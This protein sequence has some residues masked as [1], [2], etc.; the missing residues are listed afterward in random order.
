MKKNL[1]ILLAISA[2]IAMFVISGC[3]KAV[4]PT[5]TPTPTPT[6]APTVKPDVDCPKVVSTE[7]FHYYDAI[8]ENWCPWDCPSCG[9]PPCESCEPDTAVYC[10]LYTNCECLEG[11]AGE[12]CEGPVM[13]C[14][15]TPGTF[16]IVITF[17]E[18]IDP[19]KSSCALDPANWEIKVKNNERIVTELNAEAYDFEFDGKQIKVYAHVSECGENKITTFCG[20]CGPATIN[21]VFCGLICNLNDANCYAATVNGPYNGFP[22]PGVKAAPTIADEI[23]WKLGGN[24]VVADELGNYCCGFEG[25]DCCVEPI[26]ETCEPCPIE[27]S[28]CQ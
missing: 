13:T 7:V 4:T 22:Y 21:Y 14:D 24:C 1:W 5:P 8:C 10:D 6:V 19:L 3:Q 15:P 28:I 17:D 16:M 27:G 25:S 12:G 18:N 20:D 11:I 26:C 9:N 2:L 23:T